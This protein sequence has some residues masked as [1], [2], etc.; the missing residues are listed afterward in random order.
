MLEARGLLRQEAGANVAPVGMSQSRIVNHHPER[1]QLVVMEIAVIDMPLFYILFPVSRK[2][3]K[4]NWEDEDYYDSDDDTFL[5]RTGAVEK[6][7]QE[8]MKKAGKIEERPETFESLVQICYCLYTW[9]GNI[10]I[11]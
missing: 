3:K 11:F 8:R 2:R 7:R 9:L 4:K 1:L 10:T 6:K 5:D